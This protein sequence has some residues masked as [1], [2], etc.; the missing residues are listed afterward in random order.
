MKKFLYTLSVV[1]FCMSLFSNVLAADTE[2][3][4]DVNL[5]WQANTESDIAGYKVYR[6]LVPGEY[7][8]TPLAVVDVTKTSY[9][10]VI[11][12]VTTDVRYFYTLTAFELTVNDPT[13]LESVKSVEVSKLIPAKAVIANPGALV[14]TAVASAI[15]E[16]TVTWP[17][18]SD[19]VGGVAKVNIRY[20]V[21]PPIQWGTAT[22]AACDSSPCKIVGLPLGTPV[23]IKGVPFRVSPT[24]NIFGTV[25]STITVL[26]LDA[27]PNPPQGLIISQSDEKEVMLLASVQDCKEVTTSAVGSTEK[28]HKLSIRCLK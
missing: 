14:L 3:T 2:I 28:A 21:S 24:G 25:T 12:R 16:I 10:D 27:A 7:T 22:S 11:S 26:T 15:G 17:N 6:S 4:T 20:S 19:G 5:S 13:A 1:G 9:V 23:D 8:A 18:V